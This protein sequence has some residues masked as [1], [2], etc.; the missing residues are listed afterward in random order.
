MIGA[1]GNA[2]Y[3]VTKFAVRGYTEVLMAELDRSHIQVHLVHPG[4]IATNITKGTTVEAQSAQLLTTPPDEVA[5]KVIDGIRRNR[6]RIV[7]GNMARPAQVLANVAPL[8]LV[9]RMLDRGT[10]DSDPGPPPRRFS[11]RR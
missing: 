11:R 6:R 5:R 1:P 8:G 4:G 7:F 9:A 2:D 3:C 10:D